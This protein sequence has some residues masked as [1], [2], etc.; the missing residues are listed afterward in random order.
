MG[1][2]CLVEEGVKVE[3]RVAFY[4]VNNEIYVYV[5]NNIYILKVSMYI[6]NKK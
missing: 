3:F 1:K 5:Y 6:Y 4:L 2:G